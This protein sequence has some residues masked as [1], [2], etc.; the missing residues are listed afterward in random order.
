M[1]QHSKPRI[2]QKGESTLQEVFEKERTK[3]WEAFVSKFDRFTPLTRGLATHEIVQAQ[4]EATG[5]LPIT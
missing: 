3:Q 1:H 4:E 2:L 5:T